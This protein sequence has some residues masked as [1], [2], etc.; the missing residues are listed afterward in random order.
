MLFQCWAS[1]HFHLSHDYEDSITRV[2]SC[3]FMQVG[4][5]GPKSTRDARR[6]TRLIQGCS[7]RIRIF[8]INHHKRDH[9]NKADLRQDAEVD[10][11]TGEVKV[12]PTNE[13]VDSDW[14]QAY[15]P[16]EEDGCYIESPDGSIADASSMGSKVCWWH[17]A[18]GKVLGLHAGQL[19]EY[20]SETLSPLGVVVNADHL[21]E[22]EVV[23]V[24]DGTAVVLVEDETKQMEVIHPNEDGSYW[25]KF[26]RN[27]R[28]R[29][30]EK[31]REEVAKRWMAQQS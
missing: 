24:Q 11:L 30:E 20:D 6:Q 14:F 9:N 5:I 21:G 27:K 10:L 18:D 12:F 2:G 17:M 16:R 4:V 28:L 15:I 26:Q 22:R 3:I 31:A 25:R 19:V 13:L 29:L 23:V 1:G 8:S 7:E